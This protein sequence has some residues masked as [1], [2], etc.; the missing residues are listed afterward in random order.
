MSLKV[1]CRAMQV[2]QMPS[3]LY[4]KKVNYSDGSNKS[5]ATDKLA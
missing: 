5:T 1:V 2:W 4:F 3:T